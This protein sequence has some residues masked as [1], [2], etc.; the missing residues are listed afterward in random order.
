MAEKYKRIQDVEEKIHTVKLPYNAW[1]V[2]FLIDNE[3]SVPQISE[4]LEEDVSVVNEGLERLLKEGLVE[5]I[6]GEEEETQPEELVEEEA[7][8]DISMD[9]EDIEEESE[10]EVES[11]F[12]E[13]H[14][15]SDLSDLDLE[16]PTETEAEPD[17]ELSE[18]MPD[19]TDDLISVVEEEE[20]EKQPEDE[21]LDELLSENLDIDEE[22]EMDLDTGQ[23]EVEESQIDIEGVEEEQEGDFD[24]SN[25]DV[26][27][28]EEVSEEPAPAPEKPEEK[29]KEEK[30]GAKTVLVIDDSIVIR[31]MVEIALEDENFSIATAVSGKDGLAMMDE[32]NPDLIIL[33]LMLPD[34]NGIDLLKTVKASKGIPVIMLSGKDSPQMVEKA[35]AEGADAFLPK[36]FKDDELVEKIKELIG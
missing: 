24:V 31:K 6:A 14:L 28:A 8:F 4:Y 23:V 21:S 32:K 35:R 3:V 20:E 19:F 30:T 33:D 11:E 1:K 2:F 10:P 27:F 34:I 9:T 36:P 12:F 26:D 16:E 13:E 17:I 5:G 7:D 29:P 18:E 15:N 25:L 22:V